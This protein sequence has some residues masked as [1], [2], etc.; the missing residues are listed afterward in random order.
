MKK[1]FLPF[2][3]NLEASI[4]DSNR[5]PEYHL[6]VKEKTPS[7]ESML[8]VFE[9]SRKDL[10]RKCETEHMQILSLANPK[11]NNKFYNE[12]SAKSSN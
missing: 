2:L 1:F 10:T 11:W 3:E 4:L 6:E 8:K 7:Y 9:F 12:E 5:N